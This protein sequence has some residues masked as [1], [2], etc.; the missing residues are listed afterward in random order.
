MIF[1]GEGS[2]YLEKN[3]KSAVLW[4]TSSININWFKLVEG[5]V[6]IFYYLAGFSV[7]LYYQLPRE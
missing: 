4:S 1:L 3:V 6:Y 2:K 7:H 5:A